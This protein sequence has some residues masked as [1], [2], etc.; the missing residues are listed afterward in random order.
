[1]IPSRTEK[2]ALRRPAH[3][4]RRAAVQHPVE[5]YAAVDLG[6]ETLNRRVAKVLPA[7]QYSAQQNCSVDG[8]HFRSERASPAR[9]I[10]KVIAESVLA[11][12][13]ERIGDEVQ[14]RLH[15]AHD[16]RVRLI[17]SLVADAERRQSKASRGDARNRSCVVARGK[18]AILYL[19]SGRISLLPK[20]LECRLSDFFQ[21]L[22]VCSRVAIADRWRR[23]WCGR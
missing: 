16:S 10:H 18:R 20:E 9:Y 14:R 4:E 21:Q 5:I 3:R 17:A 19:S 13:L 15:A 11:E 12:W 2:S 1:M 7:R 6:R 8:G 23:W 22:I